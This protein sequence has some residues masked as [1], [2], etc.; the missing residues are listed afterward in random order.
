M[1]SDK[2]IQRQCMWIETKHL[3]K[4]HRKLKELSCSYPTPPQKKNLKKKK[5][6]L[7]NNERS[8]ER[9]E[10]L[11]KGKNSVGKAWLNVQQV[12]DN[13]KKISLLMWISDSAAVTKG[14]S[15]RN[16]R[17]MSRMEDGL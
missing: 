11:R 13:L 9:T 7:Q 5:K 8:S 10:S 17:D 14:F 16:F 2:I 6:L 12:S 3:S 15:E 4:T 1:F